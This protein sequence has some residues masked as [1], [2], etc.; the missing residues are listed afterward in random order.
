M[1]GP[2]AAVGGRPGGAGP[3]TEGLASRGG[4]NGTPTETRPVRAPA[5][6]GQRRASGLAAAAAAAAVNRPE[7]RGEPDRHGRREVLLRIRVRGPDDA[8]ELV[9]VERR[10]GHL[11]DE[12]HRVLVADGKSHAEQA[13]V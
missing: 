8:V 12:V 10:Q 9:L 13:H 5:K 4:A 2:C 3:W 11:T 6:R 7:P 1:S